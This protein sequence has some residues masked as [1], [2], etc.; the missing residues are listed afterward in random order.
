M[1][2]RRFVV[3]IL[4]LLAAGRLPAQPPVHLN[5][6]K[7]GL[8]LYGYDPVA[9][10]IDGKPVPGDAAI[11]ASHDGATYRFASEAHRK[12]FQLDPNRYLPQFGGFCAYGVAS[13]YK[14]KVDPE[15]WHIVD[16]KLYLNYDKRTQRKWLEDIPGYV[17]KAERNWPGLRDKPRRD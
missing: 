17:A 3:A 6:D 1:H 16:G 9:Y 5:V 15:A 8:G 11:T 4:G 14:V 7:E 13:G 10:F 2:R 12:E